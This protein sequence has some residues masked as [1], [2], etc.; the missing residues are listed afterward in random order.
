MSFDPAA[1]AAA[2]GIVVVGAGQA[3]GRCVE[4]LRQGGA[5]G[6]FTGAITL[7]GEEVHLPY[8]RP[9]LSKEM[10]ADDGESRIA[11]V[12]PAA[13]YAENDV[14]CRLGAQAV[15]IDRAAREVVLRDG[16][17]IPYGVLVLATGA[18]PRP[19]PIPGA[20]H[21]ACL[22]VRTLED[23]RALLP[24]LAP[25]CHVVVIGAGFIGL[26]AAAAAR[27]RGA[28]V[29]VVEL[30]ALP[31]ARC[32]PSEIAEWYVRLHEGHGV[33]FR[34][35]ASAARITDDAGRALVHLGAETIA[36]DAVV[37]GIGVIPNTEL[38]TQ[39][40]LEVRD[41]IVVDARG[42]TAD[43]AIYA[44]GD[45]TR[46]ANPLLGLELRLETWQNAQNQAIA[47]ARNIL[48]AG[49]DYA[50]LPWFWSDQFGH[51][52]Q[53]AGLPGANEQ[54]VGR[55]VLGEGPVLRFHLQDGRMVAAIGIDAARDL[56]FCRELIA[57][58]APVSADE[59]ADPTKK[60][61]DM[62]KSAKAQRAAA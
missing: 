21:P 54:V 30:G 38:A 27:A 42:R 15:A 37:I 2:R 10:L 12:R 17:R 53:I 58:G 36:A 7:V 16:E 29:T 56:R 23:S 32:V 49:K 33:T 11:W 40:G 31:M 4:A 57:L 55:G 24:K 51:N 62:Y 13:W 19:L 8:E 44:A 25:G 6:G 22:F 14:T 28:E 18:R 26:E 43:P 35:G 9:P 47:V 59:L 1:E 48:G 34:F 3:G 5:P 46:H 61:A 41:G 45:V 20:D 50:E 60:L 52:L 39:A